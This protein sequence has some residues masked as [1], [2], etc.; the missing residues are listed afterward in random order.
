MAS[1]QVQD[2]KSHFSEVIERAHSEGPQTITRHGTERAVVLSN[3]GV[4][5]VVGAETEFP[6]SPSRRPEIRR[7]RNRARS[8]HRPRYRI[9]MAGRG[10]LL[11]TNVVSETRRTRAHPS[12]MAF[13][14][15]IDPSNL[16]ISVLTM[17]ELRK[18]VEI[19]RRSSPNAARDLEDWVDK[20]ERDFG[21]R[22]LPVD[23]I[24][25]SRWGR[26]LGRPK[27]PGDRHLNWRDRLDARPYTGHSQSQG[28]R[29]IRSRTAKSL[30][31]RPPESFR[32][33][34]RRQQGRARHV[35]PSRTIVR[36]PR[37]DLPGGNAG[38]GPE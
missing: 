15:S 2:A 37:L 5:C 23:V 14:A 12:V 7:F 19:Q 20:T 28:L 30:R 29:V 33:L 31:R 17:G 24:S 16:F 27:R 38:T 36:D 34:L 9:L 4:S 8:R 25:A 26:P 32:R 11:D 18:G 3:R 10:Y 21:D 13:L 6:G 1:W 22:I 35:R